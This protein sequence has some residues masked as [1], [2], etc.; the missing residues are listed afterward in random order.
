MAKITGIEHLAV[1]VED[2]ESALT[3]WRDSLGLAVTHE[4]AEEGQGVR[5]AFMPVGDAAVELVQP[6]KDEGGVTRFIE[7]RGPGMHHLCVAVD[8]LDGMIAR[9][10]ERDVRLT[11]DEPYTNASGRRLIFVHPAAT[12]G[13]LLELYEARSESEVGD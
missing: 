7:K 6:L 8:D 1:V 11:S 2:I 10:K 12:G 4:A 9:L 3:F 13:V 5:V